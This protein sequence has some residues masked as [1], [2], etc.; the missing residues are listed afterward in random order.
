M[1]IIISNI[2]IMSLAY[3]DIIIII[4]IMCDIMCKWLLSITMYCIITMII[5]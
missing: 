1:Y 3:N 4:I 2:V 5:M